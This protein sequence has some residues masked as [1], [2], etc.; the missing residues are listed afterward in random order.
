MTDLI[1]ALVIIIWEGLFKGMQDSIMRS[2]HGFKWENKYK[3]PFENVSSMK[4]GWYKVYHDFYRL[5]YKEKFPFSATAL[6]SLTDSWHTMGLV[7]FAGLAIGLSV[8]TTWWFFIAAF[9]L[10]SIAFHLTYTFIDDADR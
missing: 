6:V 3:Q 8:I 9:A 4:P 1:I 2:G 10:R 5:P 7:R